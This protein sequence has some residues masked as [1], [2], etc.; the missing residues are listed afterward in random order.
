MPS[1]VYYKLLLW[2][3]VFLLQPH[4]GSLLCEQ[5]LWA[6]PLQHDWQCFPTGGRNALPCCIARLGHVTSISQWKGSWHDICHNGAET[7]ADVIAGWDQPGESHVWC[8]SCR[9]VPWSKPN[10]NHSPYATWMRNT[11]CKPLR[12]WDVC[13]IPA[14]LPPSIQTN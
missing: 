7:L 13:H 12:L 9:L 2:P 4:T 11:C 8:C 10:T 5:I 14:P 6:H 1:I 3:I